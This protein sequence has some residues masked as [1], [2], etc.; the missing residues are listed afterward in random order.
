MTEGR[1]ILYIDMAYSHAAVQKNA[2]HEFFETRHSGD[3]FS[4]VWG[5]HPLA[6][7]VDEPFNAIKTIEFSPRQ[8]I[9]EGAAALYDWPRFL[10]PLNLL[11]SQLRLFR[12]VLAVVRREKIDL[13]VATDP[14]FGGLFGLLLKKLSGV[15]LAIAVYAEF[16]LAYRTF[17]VLVMPRLFPWLWLQNI[18][19]R[20]AL[21]GADFVIG[22]TE[23]YRQWAVRHG[24][25]DARS[26]VIPIARNIQ[27]FHLVAPAE[28]SGFNELRNDLQIPEAS[29]YLLMASRLIPVKFVE[30]GVKAMIHAVGQDRD[31]VAIVAGEGYLQE[32]LQAQ[33]D[34]AGLTGRIKFVGKL[35]QR[36]LSILFPHCI[37]VSPLTGMAL[38]EAGLGGCPVVAYDIDWQ[39]EMVIDGETGFIVPMGDWQQLGERALQIANDPALRERLSE[40]MRSLAVRLSDRERIAQIEHAVFDRIIDGDTLA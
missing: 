25:D 21:S 19:V 30:D 26:A 22:G 9:I 23:V 32:P 14:G 34:A 20:I 2:H 39:S 28:R 11:V 1:K 36:Q 29:D 16:D 33:V 5:L 7:L 17:K 4:H 40:N 24:G 12:M 18:V 38:V 15:P 13:I 8:T 6:D 35:S 27:S 37:T 3:Y 31:L 10:T